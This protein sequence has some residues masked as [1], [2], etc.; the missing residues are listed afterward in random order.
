MASVVAQGEDLIGGVVRAGWMKNWETVHLVLGADADR[1]ARCFAFGML[2][3]TLTAIGLPQ[4]REGSQE[5]R[6][7]SGRTRLS[8]RLPHPAA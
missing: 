8:A 5:D 6:M 4:A 2:G 3:N 7:P 1:T